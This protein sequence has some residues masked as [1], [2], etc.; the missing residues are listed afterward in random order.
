MEIKVKVQVNISEAKEA[1]ERLVK[2]NL[3]QKL[4][5]YLKKFDSKEDSE[6]LI[7]IKIDKNKKD[8]F[9]WVLYANLDGKIF[10]YSRED[11]KKLDDLINNLFDHFKEEISDM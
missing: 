9:N 8:R 7:E 6:W 1:S 11:Y 2:D 3:E 10:R 4:D 5:S